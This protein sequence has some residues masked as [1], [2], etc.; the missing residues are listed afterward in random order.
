MS[1]EWYS[2]LYIGIRGNLLV[3]TCTTLPNRHIWSVGTSTTFPNRHIHSSNGH[4]Y[5]VETGCEQAYPFGRNGCNLRSR[6]IYSHTTFNVGINIFLLF[7]V[8]FRS[9][10]MAI[11]DWNISLIWKQNWTCEYATFIANKMR[12]Y[13][14]HL[15]RI[16]AAGLA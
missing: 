5:S 8:S 11:F 14:N 16:W 4:I 2:A 1:L 3:V 13:S 15:P 12:T 7:L 6:H 10:S 9:Y